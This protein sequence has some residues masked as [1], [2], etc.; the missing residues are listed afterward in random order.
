MGN[1]REIFKSVLDDGTYLAGYSTRYGGVSKGKYE[2][3]NLA[4]HVG[5]DEKSVYKNREILKEYLG[6]KK[7]IFMHQTHSDIIKILKNESENLG[8]CDGIITNMRSIGLCVMV[9]D[10]SPILLVSKNA[11]AAIHAGRQG[12]IK[13]IVSKCVK[14]MR[15]KF[16][17]H[18]IKAYIGANISAKNYEIGDMDLGEFN[19]YK[20]GKNFDINMALADEFDKL[21]IKN[22][23]FSNQC[24]FESD[25]FFSYRKSGVT[26]RFAGVVGFK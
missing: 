19:A 2:S 13:R 25:E 14:I 26:G 4:L 15:D 10:C 7:L 11:V 18:D 16:N 5:D 21:N 1:S 12:V 8:E 17:A 22:T 9:A 23:F 6:F 3:L 20:N 24:T